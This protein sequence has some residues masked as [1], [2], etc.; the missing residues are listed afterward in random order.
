MNGEPW[1]YALY[2]LVPFLFLA[3]LYVVIR[4]TLG[5][6]YRRPTKEERLA[7]LTAEKDRALDS[8]NFGWITE[9]QYKRKT[10]RIDA[11]ISEL[12]REP[13]S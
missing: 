7:Q 2:L 5:R 9:I 11:F 13:G 8:L 3:I 10:A 4:V 6:Y 1:C 12:F